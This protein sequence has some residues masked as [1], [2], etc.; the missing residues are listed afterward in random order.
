MNETRSSISKVD[1]Y[2]TIGEFW[3]LADLNA[4]WD[5]TRPAEFEID[6]K[7]NVILYPMPRDLSD[8]VRDEAKTKGVLPSDLLESWIREK[9]DG[10]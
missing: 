8:Q 3:D 7:E 4:F 6:L 1:S 10:D 2:Q 9:L 5:K